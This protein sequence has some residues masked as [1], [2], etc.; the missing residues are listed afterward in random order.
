MVLPDGKKSLTDRQTDTQ[1]PHDG[2]GRAWCKNWRYVRSF[3]QN[4]WT[5]QTDGR[6]PHTTAWAALMISSRGKQAVWPP[7]SADTVCPRASV[8]LTFDHLTLKLVCK[9]HASKVGN[10][11][12]KFGHA[13]PVGS[14]TIRYV[15]YATDGQTDRQTVRQHSSFIARQHTYARYWYTNSLRP[16]VRLS[17]TFLYSMKMT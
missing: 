5:W 17:I 13:R 3:Q 2:K 4:T 1:T 10:L 15:G 12:S 14:R 16:S 7:G 8:T 9:S 6:T 11:H